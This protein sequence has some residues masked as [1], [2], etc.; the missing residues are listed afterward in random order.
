MDPD[1]SNAVNL[2]NSESNNLAPVWSPDGSQIAFMSDIE[3][4][5][6]S[7]WTHATRQNVKDLP[8]M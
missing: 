4:K 6:N 3:T 8:L 2:T 7:N 5:N 1:G